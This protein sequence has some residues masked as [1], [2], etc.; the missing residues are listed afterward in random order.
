MTAFF[1]LMI[2]FGN[3]C[4]LVALIMHVEQTEGTRKKRV[5]IKGKKVPIKKEDWNWDDEEDDDDEPE[6]VLDQI[7]DRHILDFM[8][9]KGYPIIDK[10]KKKRSNKKEQ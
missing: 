8:V 4:L 10:R 5:V 2:F 3:M 6:E 1:L 7:T 9:E